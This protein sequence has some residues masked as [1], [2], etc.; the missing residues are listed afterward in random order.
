M[1]DYPYNVTYST[2]QDFVMVATFLELSDPGSLQGFEGVFEVRASLDAVRTILY[3]DSTPN[4][5]CE[6]TL[7]VDDGTVLV[8]INKKMLATLPTSAW[9]RFWL[10][11]LSNGGAAIGFVGRMTRQRR[12]GGVVP[13]LTGTATTE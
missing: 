8:T 11:N 10:R 1:A 12:F 6:T 5:D 9:Y 2:E 3:V 7:V 4:D 13:V